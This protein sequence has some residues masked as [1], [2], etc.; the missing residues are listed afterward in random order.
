MIKVRMSQLKSDLERV[1][2]TRHL[3]R[4][5]SKR[6]PVPQAVLV[7]YTNSGKS[8]L[9]N[10]LTD[11][12]VL[13]ANKLFATLDPT[14]RRIVLPNHREVLLT[15]SV[16]F[17]RKLPH[18]LVEAFKATL[19]EVQ[20]ADLL[21]HV[22]DASNPLWESHKRATEQVLSELDCLSKPILEVFNKMDC[23]G[24]REFGLT[25]S[26]RRVYVSALQK[27]NIDL[28]LEKIS[29][30]L[31][32]DLRRVKV[33]FPQG[34]GDLLA[35]AHREGKIMEEDYS[36]DYIRLTVDLPLKRVEQWKKNGFII[37]DF[38]PLP[39]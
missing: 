20:G 12:G 29:E 32:G 4:E 18:E 38:M 24:D 23:F 33:I 39:L 1:R 35:I 36:E 6:T 8:T 21:L 9:F 30:A 37:S 16:G 28:L 10:T 3:Q 15:D 31:Q 27:T 17:I 5:K 7:G 26:H 25:Q 13:V 14:T 11:G 2:N 22:I 34:R 19:E